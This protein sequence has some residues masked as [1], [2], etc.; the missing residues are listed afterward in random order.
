MSRLL[1]FVSSLFG[2]ASLIAVVLACGV[3]ERPARAGGSMSSDNN[4]ILC[5]IGGVGCTSVST[6]VPGICVTGLME[7]CVCL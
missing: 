3:M 5:G 2:A 7:S 6:C 1:S 4:P